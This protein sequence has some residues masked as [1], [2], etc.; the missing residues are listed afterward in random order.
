MS[1]NIE[2]IVNKVIPEAPDYQSAGYCQGIDWARDLLKQA[3]TEGKLVVPMSEENIMKVI[4]QY[5]S[6]YEVDIST[7][8]QFD[9]AKAIYKAKFNDK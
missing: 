7:H 6:D 5:A 3:L 2:E 4:R 9:L 8:R 1:K